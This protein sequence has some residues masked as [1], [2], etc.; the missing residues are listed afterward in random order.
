MVDRYCTIQDVQDYLDIT[1]TTTDYP[2]QTLVEDWITAS[3]NDIDNYTGTKFDLGTETKIISFPTSSNVIF[4]DRVPV[5]NITEI[6]VRTD[7]TDIAPVFGKVLTTGVDYSLDDA[8]IGLVLLS[9]YYQG[10]KRLQVTYDGGSATVDLMVKELCLAMV[11]KRYY[12]SI[13][14]ISSLD[15]EIVSISSIKVREKSNDAIK[16]SL[17]QID[18]EIKDKLRKLPRA[19]SAR[20]FGVTIY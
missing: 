14:G 19:N 2:K 3:E 15:T 13:L 5:T 20:M 9:E 12:E 11:K 4:L 7:G 8:N 16:Y 6:R 1:I 10:S 17:E 18:K